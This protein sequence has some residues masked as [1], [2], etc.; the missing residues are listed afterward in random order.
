MLVGM[1]IVAAVMATTLMATAGGCGG[2]LAGAGHVVVSRGRSLGQR[3]Q[4]L[5]LQALLAATARQGHPSFP[6]DCIHPVWLHHHA[7]LWAPGTWWVLCGEAALNRELTFGVAQR[8]LEG[9]KLRRRLEMSSGIGLAGLF[10]FR[11]G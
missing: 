3:L 10:G 7:P 2:R 11:Y 9:V 5:Q 1:V 4:H 6:A 8:C